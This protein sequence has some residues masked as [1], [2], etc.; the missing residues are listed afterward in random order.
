MVGV[1]VFQVCLAMGAL[2]PEVQRA[3]GL[4]ASVQHSLSVDQGNESSDEDLCQSAN[5]SVHRRPCSF[6]P[7]AAGGGGGGGDEGASVGDGTGEEGE[8]GTAA[9]TL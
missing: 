5:V 3:D 9:E 1:D 2:S 8:A 4:I 6:S 7:C